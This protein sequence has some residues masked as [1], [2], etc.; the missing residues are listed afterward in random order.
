MVELRVTI[1][2]RLNKILDEVVESGIFRSKAHLFRFA[3]LHLLIEN[4]LLKEKIK[5]RT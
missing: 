1:D 4:D 5:K 2:E 3:V